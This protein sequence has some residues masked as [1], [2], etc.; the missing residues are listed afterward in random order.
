M[1]MPK[2]TLHYF[3][4]LFLCVNPIKKMNREFFISRDGN[5]NH[6]LLLFDNGNNDRNI[7]NTQKNNDT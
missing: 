5:T 1:N 7:G 4:V 2:T 6:S 3:Y